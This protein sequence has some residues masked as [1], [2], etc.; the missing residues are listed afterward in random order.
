MATQIQRTPN[1]FVWRGLSEDDGSSNPWWKSSHIYRG[2]E[3]RCPFCAGVYEHS[4]DKWP[5]AMRISDRC[6]LCGFEH[7]LNDGH[8]DQDF[9][10]NSYVRT[11]REM[12]INDSELGL[13]ELGSHLKRNFTDVYSLSSRRFELLVEDVFRNLGYATRITKCTRDNGYDIILLEHNQNK[14]IIVEVKRYAV[15]RK[16]GVATVREVLG[17]QLL[18]GFREAII[19]TSSE[20]SSIARKERDLG[21][22][23]GY[24]L[25]L[26]DASDLLS[27]LELYNAS[28]PP[29]SRID[30]SRA[31]GE[32]IK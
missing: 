6:T 32:Q 11:L 4:V 12:S 1:L 22:L 30:F 7:G 13:D 3:K 18:R 26:L 28:L 8:G 24:N 5:T 17:V 19:V 23:N 15:A 31:L 16:V 21:A 27:A 9:W 10:Y 14:Q 25:T 20:F 29:L 2:F